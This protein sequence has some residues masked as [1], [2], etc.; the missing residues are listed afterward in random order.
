MT[1]KI[2]T[3][4]RFPNGSWSTGGRADDPDYAA[5]NVYRVPADDEKEAKRKGQAEHR[6]AL[7]NAAKQSSQSA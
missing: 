4:A 6:K 5:C 3:V 2:W 1:T 7:R